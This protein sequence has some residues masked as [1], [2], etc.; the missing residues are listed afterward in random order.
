MIISLFF[1][2]SILT[3]GMLTT[4]TSLRIVCMMVV[5]AVNGCGEVTRID[6]PFIQLY[7]C[8]LIDFLLME[9][10]RSRSPLLLLRME[11]RAH[12]I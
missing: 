4:E 9:Y 6:P 11:Y 7:Q 3:Y 1:I 2:K 10:N 8:C 5:D 12:P